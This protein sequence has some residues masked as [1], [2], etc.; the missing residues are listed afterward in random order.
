MP[1]S[2]IAPALARAVVVAEDARFWEHEGVDWEAVREAA[3]KNWE[4]GKLKVGGVD[5]HAAARQEP[6]PLAR[7]HAL[8]QAP[9]ARRSPGGSST[10]LSKK[11]I[12]ELYLNVIEF[13]PRTY[14][15]E[16]AARRYFGKSARELST[17][18]S[19]DSRRRH[20]LARGSTIPC[21]TADRV[22]RRARR[23]LGRM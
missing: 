9:R 2:R 3:E 4:K 7:A 23:I 14:G 17:R 13:G 12:L 18:G 5:D 1:L 6:L 22:E 19:G 15:A 20:P 10:T 16:A 8:A 21:A 11:R